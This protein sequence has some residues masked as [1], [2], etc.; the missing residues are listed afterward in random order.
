MGPL[1]LDRLLNLW[2]LRI[3]ITRIG[4][5]DLLEIEI[6]FSVRFEFKI[7]VSATEPDDPATAAATTD[8]PAATVLDAPANDGS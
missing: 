7:S 4:V 1:A 6:K 8:I 2:Y 5:I 3:W